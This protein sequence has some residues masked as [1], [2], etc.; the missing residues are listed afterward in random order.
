[1]NLDQF[2]A[3]GQQVEKL[4][5]AVTSG[6]TGTPFYI[7]QDSNKKKRN[8]ADTVYFGRMAGYSIGEK[9]N[10]LK[11]WTKVNRKSNFKSWAENINPIDVTRLSDNEIK[12]LVAQ[13][14]KD[15]SRKAF[16]GYASALESI[17]NYLEKHDPKVRFRNVTS[18]IAMSEAINEKSKAL[19]HK[20]FGVYCVSRYSNVENGMIAQQRN[21]GLAVF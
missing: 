17:V 6:S 19:I 21:D 12:S 3:E 4:T 9:L 18:V 14:S 8:T 16:L 11:I 7:Y 5:R 13:I 20:Y 2:L 1:D 15:Q 10:Y